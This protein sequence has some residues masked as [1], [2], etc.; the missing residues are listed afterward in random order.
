MDAI[1]SN[2]RID[3]KGW[4]VKRI[5]PK[6]N[7][8]INEEWISD[9]TRFSCDG[10]LNNRIDSPY[11]KINGKLTATWGNAFEFIKSNVVNKKVLVD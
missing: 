9:K 11:I 6:I 5:L 3:S 7:E 4:E 1:G 10:L 8:D 2:I